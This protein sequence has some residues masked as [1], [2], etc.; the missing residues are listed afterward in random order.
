MVP[1]FCGLSPDTAQI[2]IHAFEEHEK[3]MHLKE[4]EEAENN[5]RRRQIEE[6]QMS[7]GGAGVPPAYDQ[8]I[9]KFSHIL[10]RCWIY[11]F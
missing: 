1:H 3:K 4:L 10:H 6:L 2:L 8:G 11:I 9:C 7:A 5:E